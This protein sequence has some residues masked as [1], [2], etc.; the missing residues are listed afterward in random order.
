M[1]TA[2]QAAALMTLHP[3]TPDQAEAAEDA[4]YRRNA[5]AVPAGLF[6]V[7]CALRSRLTAFTRAATPSRFAAPVKS[8]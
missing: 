8:L 1:S 6:V 3:A 4:Y 2:L 5:T 7:L